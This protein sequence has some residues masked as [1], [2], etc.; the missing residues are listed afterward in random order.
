MS[1]PPTQ[2]DIVNGLLDQN[3]ALKTSIETTVATEN[4]KQQYQAT[5]I[6]TLVWWNNV[7]YYAYFVLL[8]VVMLFLL[9]Q[10]VPWMHVAAMAVGLA[11]YPFVIDYLLIQAYNVCMF[12]WQVSVGQVF[13]PI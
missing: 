9:Y 2:Q 6:D 7:M 5:E 8:V 3:A 1:T 12:M 4:R 11:L 13:T 10:R